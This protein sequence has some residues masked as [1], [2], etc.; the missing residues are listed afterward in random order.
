MFEPKIL[1]KNIKKFR[2]AKGVSQTELAGILGISPQSVSKWECG[3]T[4]PDIVNLCAMA[5]FFN[6][7][8]ES[9]IGSPEKNGKLMIGVDGGGTKTEF[10]MFD[11][12]GNI[13]DRTVLSGCNPNVVGVDGAVSVLKSGINELLSKNPGVA[14]IYIGAAGFLLSNKVSEIKNKLMEAYPNV[15]LRC[16]SDMLN[17]VASC[18]NSDKCIGAVC[19]T[20]FVTY[21]KIK[22]ELIRYGGWG[23]LLSQKGSGFDIGRDAIY[24]ALDDEEGTGKNTLIT[25]MIKDKISFPLEN[26]VSAVYKNGQAYIASFAPVV[27]DAYE[28]GDKLAENILKENA[29]AVSDI[30][31]FISDKY[32]ITKN[33]VLSGSLISSNDIYI[34]LIKEK[35][36]SGI[37]VIVP[38]LPQIYGACRLC[39]D[40]CGVDARELEK[41]FVTDYNKLNGVKLC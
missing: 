6:V 3:N 23:Y 25:Q 2:M 31:N 39:A 19:G 40:M 9:F 18:T 1:T 17:V 4:I 32:Q 27:F 33:V 15:K 16:K 21:A 12:N 38:N 36:N 22:G 5:E 20:G 14:G 13:L 30:L 7:S 41:N 8:L 24:S 26:L 28:A 11:E 29:Y 34:G 10:V 35:L 37:E